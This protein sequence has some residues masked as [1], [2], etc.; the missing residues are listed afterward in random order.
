MSDNAG[1]KRNLTLECVEMQKTSLDIIKEAYSSKFELKDQ[2][3]EVD[4]RIKEVDQRTASE[5]KVIHSELDI[6]RKET[7]DTRGELIEVR[8]ENAKAAANFKEFQE[9]LKPVLDAF[10]RG[11]TLKSKI[12]TFAIGYTVMIA[13][14]PQ[15]QPRVI[16]ESLIKLMAI[17]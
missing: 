13:V 7:H 2:I 17:L 1:E 9:E 3:R 5:I 6:I 16:L 8:R 14:F 4:E 10:H 11:L 15:V 12:G